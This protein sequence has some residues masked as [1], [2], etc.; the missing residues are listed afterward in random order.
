LQTYDI[1][2]RQTV[3]HHDALTA[4]SRQL[5]RSAIAGMSAIS[6]ITITETKIT[7]ATR[8]INRN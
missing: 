8:S 7:I 3:L 1:T 4:F 6:K 5:P 2:A